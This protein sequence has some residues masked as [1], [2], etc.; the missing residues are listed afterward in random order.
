M[1]DTDEMQ[2]ITGSHVILVEGKD[3][4]NF[5]GELL[6]TL[7]FDTTVDIRDVGG[8]NQFKNK[9]DTLI[10]TTNWK[11]VTRVA[12]IRDADDSYQSAY[13]SICDSLAHVGL[14]VPEQTLSFTS[15]RPSVGVFIMPNNADKGNLED[16]C[17]QSI[18]TSAV[19]ECI[20]N[21]WD[22]ICDRGV[23]PKNRSKSQVQ[24]YLSTMPE[25]C[26][27]LGRAAIQGHWNFSSPQFND[28]KNFMSDFL[29]D[30]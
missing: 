30:I 9:L 19:I 23:Q 1:F 15:G 6:K 14:T 24:T 7:L 10:K 27:S 18:S 4:V 5:I 29:T 22:C 21:F 28:L 26:T 13:Q 2:S 3:E 17:L 12:I 25:T 16:L 8:K 11:K 20:S